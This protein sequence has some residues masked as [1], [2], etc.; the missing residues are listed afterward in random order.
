[1]NLKAIILSITVL[2]VTVFQING[3]SQIDSGKTD[4]EQII[5]VINDYIIG[6]SYSYPNKL[7]AAFIPEAKMFLDKDG[8]CQLTDI[9]VLL[10][11]S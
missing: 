7:K 11:R 9:M 3:Q 1:M 10:W 5:S 8:D 2:F 6:T 4:D